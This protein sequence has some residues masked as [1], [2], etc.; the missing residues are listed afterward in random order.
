MTLKKFVDITLSIEEERAI[1]TT[2]QILR[3]ICNEFS[4][5]DGCPFN[6]MCDQSG[7]YPHI[8][9]EDFVKSCKKD[10]TND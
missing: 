5:C 4:D 6:G 3:E 1:K 10:L 8:F 9:L 2:A 7:S